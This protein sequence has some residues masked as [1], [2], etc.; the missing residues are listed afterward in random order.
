MDE[1]EETQKMEE[2][3][4]KSNRKDFIVRRLKTLLPGCTTSLAAMQDENGA[5]TNDPAAKAD[6]YF[7]RVHRAPAP[8]QEFLA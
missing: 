7:R 3:Q 6:T 1:M 8:Q 4:D 2:S 5:V